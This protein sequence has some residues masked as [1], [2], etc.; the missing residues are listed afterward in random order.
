MNGE[1][2]AAQVLLM[3]L[4]IGMALGGGFAL[5]WGAAWWL[6]FTLP[7]LRW[8]RHGRELPHA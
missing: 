1:A 4:L 6:V 3:I 8:S 2:E 5:L 7:E